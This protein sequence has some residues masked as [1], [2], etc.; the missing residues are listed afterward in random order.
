MKSKKLKF[1]FLFI[2]LI[3]AL[4]FDAAAQTADEQRNVTEKQ[5][6][7]DLQSA[8]VLITANV[9]AKELQFEAVPNPTVEFPGTKKRQTL[10]ESDRENLPRSVE[11]GVTYRN[12]GIRLRIASRFAD[13]DRIVSEALGETLIVSEG[14]SSKDLREKTQV[15]SVSEKS[16]KKS[17]K[18][19]LVKPERRKNKERK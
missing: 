17:E 9:R 11:P 16:D 1:V 7:I 4:S 3:S 13:I 14:N 5:D 2:C 19:K 8:D 12:I 15:P 10:W 18:T 6:A